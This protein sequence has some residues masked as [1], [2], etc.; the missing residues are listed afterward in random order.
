MFS[1]IKIFVLLFNLLLKDIFFSSSVLSSCSLKIKLFLCFSLKSLPDISNW[2]TS[3]I[4]NMTRIFY[5]CSSLKSLPD[6]SKWNTNNVTDISSLFYN[7]YSLELLPDI[8][9]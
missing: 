8:S 6:I 2:N 3:K 7:C 9:K 5:N 4:T 1:F